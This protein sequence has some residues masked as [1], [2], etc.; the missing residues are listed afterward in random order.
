MSIFNSGAEL[1]WSH[2]YCFQYRCPKCSTILAM[3]SNLSPKFREP[4]SAILRSTTSISEIARKS[5]VSRNT[6]HS[7]LRGDAEPRLDA[8]EE[9]LL[10]IGFKPTV[11][12]PVLSDGHAAAAARILLGDTALKSTDEVQAWID[13]FNRWKISSKDALIAAAHE[14]SNPLGRVDA[15]HFL[16]D[17]TIRVAS[18][19]QASG[20]A[21]AISQGEG[22]SIVWCEDPAAV[23]ASL[24]ERVRRSPAPVHGGT[25]LVGAVGCELQGREKIDGIYHVTE[26]Q[27]AIDWR[28]NV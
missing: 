15:I 10:T 23:A 20:Q 12:A 2:L 24:P 5:G 9:V 8:L 19:A 21:W 27:N 28:N 4:L 11:Q 26:L 3:A 6:I 7:W 22:G 17:H 13:R 25:C 14:A 18:A 16:G 1:D